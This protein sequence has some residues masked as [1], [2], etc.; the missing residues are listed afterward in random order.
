MLGELL[1]FQDRL[2]LWLPEPLL[3]P[4]PVKVSVEVEGEALLVTVNVP[5]KEP[6]V[7]GLK[8]TVTGRVAPAAI[9]TGRESPPMVKTELF[10]LAAVTVTFAPVAF[11]VAVPGALVPSATLP[12]ASVD[13][14]IVSCPAAE[15]PVPE[16]ATV[17]DGFD[18]SEAMVTVPLA[19]PA[20]VG[21][22]F[23]LTVAV[24]PA[25]KV[26]GVVIPLTVNPVPVMLT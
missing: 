17:K 4:V 8:V 1:A 12:K 3:V 11:R 26:R 14:V 16:T 24:P 18:A 19:D 22:N 7:C 10:V 20:D 6:A 25:V 5:V 9:V 23:T 21:A 2:T 13:G 15:A